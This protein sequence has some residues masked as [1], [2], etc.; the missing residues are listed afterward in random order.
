MIKVHCDD[1]LKDRIER[2]S[3]SCRQLFNP[4][5]VAG[6]RYFLS[7]GVTGGY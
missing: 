1:E 6:L 2:N 3:F 4:F 5:G 7:A